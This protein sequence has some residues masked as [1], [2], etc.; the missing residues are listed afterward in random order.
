MKT[1]LESKRG[2]YLGKYEGYLE[3]QRS[4]MPTF[5]ITWDTAIFLLTMKD[6]M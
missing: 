4:I 3:N 1:A 2:T 5:P 6:Q